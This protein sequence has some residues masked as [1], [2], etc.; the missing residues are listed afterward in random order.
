MQSKNRVY[1]KDLRRFIY[2]QINSEK[3]SNIRYPMPNKI[4]SYPPNVVQ[5][6]NFLNYQYS[7]VPSESYFLNRE[8]N[9]NALGYPRDEG[10]FPVQRNNNLPFSY[11]NNKYKPESKI[12]H[13][14]ISSKKEYTNDGEEDTSSGMPINI[15]K[16]TY[17]IDS[18]NRYKK[19]SI[20]K[21]EENIPPSKIYISET[22]PYNKKEIPH[23]LRPSREKDGYKRGVI[24]LNIKNK[25]GTPDALR[26]IILIQRWWKKNLYNN[27]RNFERYTTVINRQSI[28]RNNPLNNNKEGN[29]FIIQTTRV[30]VFKRPY[31][32]K[33]LIKPE[34]IT[35]ENKVN[36][37]EKNE[38][39]NLEIILDRDSLKQNMVN[40]WNEE[41]VLSP[42]EQLCFI[43]NENFSRE[44][45]LRNAKIKNYE[46]E[47]KQL[48]LALTKKEKELNDLS[49]KLKSFQNKKEL[50]KKLIT[51]QLVDNL[52]INDDKNIIIPYTPSIECTE[53]FEILPIEKEPLKKQL[54]DNLFIQRNLEHIP[55]IVPSIFSEDKTIIEA[56]DNIEIIPLE[57]EPLKKQLIDNLFIEKTI[58]IKPQ[59]I[60]QK[61]DKNSITIANSLN[62]QNSIEANES[63]EIYP[64]QKE[65]L[66]KQFI[67]SLYIKK[68]D[69]IK[70]QNVSE[71]IDNIE[72][73][74]IEE[75]KILEKQL[76]DDL[77][78]EREQSIKP[79]NIAQHIDTLTIYKTQRPDNII[80][81]EYY[82]ELL[83]L[84]TPPL[85]KQFVNDI[86]IEKTLK[87]ENII[88]NIDN[89]YLYEIPKANNLIQARDSIEICSLENEP[90]QLQF[91]DELFIEKIPYSFKNLEMEGFE[92][93]TVLK[94]DKKN[95]YYQE[96][97]AFIIDSL[98]KKENEIQKADLMTILK[99]PRAQN[100][101]EISATI[102]IPSKEKVSLQIEELD[103]VFIE[104]K[105]IIPENQIQN[106]DTLQFN[107]IIKES[108]II[109]EQ[110]NSINLLEKEKD[111]LI[112]Q[113]LDSIILETMPRIEN[114]INPIDTLLIEGISHPLNNI[115]SID[116]VILPAIQKSE[117]EISENIEIYIPP[118]EKEV[119]INQNID[120]IN[121][122]SIQK[123]ENQMQSMDKIYLEEIKKPDFIIQENDYVYIPRKERELNQNQN[124]DSITI[125]SQ[126]KKENI[127]QSLDKIVLNSIDIPDYLIQKSEDLFIE[128]EQ[129][130]PYEFQSVDNLL[131]EGYS[132][133]ENNKIQRID[134]FTIVK[135]F[136]FS[137]RIDKMDT[138]YIP[139]K[140]KTPLTSQIVD[141]IY[142]E[143]NVFQYDNNNQIQK[144]DTINILRKPKEEN[145]IEKNDE[146]ILYPEEKQG[147]L[148]IQSLDQLMIEREPKGELI[149]QGIDK[150]ELQEL[151]KESK[152]YIQI[153]NETFVILSS[154]KIEENKEIS[155]NSIFI[156][157]LD[158]NNYVIE[159]VE[160]IDLLPSKKKS[161][162]DKYNIEALNYIYIPPKEKEKLSTQL[163]ESIFIENEESPEKIFSITEIEAKESIYIPPKEKESLLNENRDSI[164][165]EGFE[166]QENKIEYKD[167]ISIS[168]D[169]KFDTENNKISNEEIIKIQGI[170][171]DQEI[172]NELVNSILIEGVNNNENIKIE[173]IEEINLLEID[174]PKYIIEE[175]EYILITPEEKEELKNIKCD[176]LLIEGESL[177]ENEIQ[178]AECI[179]ILK[180]EKSF[181]YEI[182]LLDSFYLQEITKAPLQYENIDNILF[183]ESVPEKQDQINS[184]VQDINITI[185]PEKKINKLEYQLVDD[186]F[187]EGQDKVQNEIQKLETLI[188]SSTKK[189]F[190][191]M[192]LAD[193]ISLEIKPNLKSPKKPEYKYINQIEK[194]INLYIEPKEK[195]PLENEVMD[196]LTIDG[197]TI[198]EYEVQEILEFTLEKTLKNKDFKPENII[199]LLIKSKDKEPLQ[200]QLADSLFIEKI[201]NEENIIKTDNLN[202]EN[203]CNI[204]I[205]PLTKKDL[206]M[207]NADNF[208]I[209][210]IKLAPLLNEEKEK[211]EDL[212]LPC[213]KNAE[214]EI[215]KAEEIFIGPININEQY[216]IELINKNNLDKD[217]LKL[218][219]KNKEKEEEIKLKPKIEFVKDRMDSL[220]FSGIIKKDNE[221]KEEKE[222]IKDDK[223]VKVKEE[224]K[225]EPEEKDDNV[226]DEEDNEKQKLKAK[227]N[228][229]EKGDKK[230]KEDKE[231]KKDKEESPKIIEHQNN[232]K[233]NPRMFI[234][235]TENREKDFSIKQNI[236]KEE[237][238]KKPKIESQNII[239]HETTLFIQ[240]EKLSQDEKP[241]QKEKLPQK[242][243]YLLYLE[244]WKKEKIPQKAIQL[245]FE[246][247]KE[248]IIV[249]NI[250]EE[251]LIIPKKIPLT[252]VQEE[253]FNLD[254]N[255]PSDPFQE[256]IKTQDNKYYKFKSPIQPKSEINIHIPNTI[257]I[258]PKKEI[259]SLVNL[260]ST[261]LDS[262]NL[263]GNISPEYYQQLILI[264][265]KYLSNKDSIQPTSE[266][267]LFIPKM[268]SSPASN[269][270]QIKQERK[271]EYTPEVKIQVEIKGKQ[272]KPY[273]IENKGYFIINSYTRPSKN[274]IV[275][276]SCFGF[277]AQPKKLGLVSQDFGV[278][279]PP[280]EKNINWNLSNKTQRSQL[281]FI[282]GTNNKITW[283]T[284][285][286]RQKC[287]KFKIPSSKA[288]N[289][290][291]LSINKFFITITGNNLHDQDNLRKQ[292]VVKSII[293]KKPKEKELEENQDEFDPF[294]FCKKR[295]TTKYDNLFKERKT[296]SVKMKE[297]NDNSN[298]IFPPKNLNNKIKGNKD[299]DGIRIITNKERK[300]DINLIE[301]KNKNKLKL[302]NKDNNKPQTLFKKKEKNM[303][304][305]RDSGGPKIFFH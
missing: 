262:F 102:F 35:K 199:H 276:G 273:I 138:L 100:S 73:A 145:K 137:N 278:Q 294:S 82:C 19:I 84:D 224:K 236:K 195:I 295:D 23:K 136:K 249:P 27:K 233:E 58:P 142:I 130:D 256:S 200:K 120:S 4:T 163:A 55:N 259:I 232:I 172:K 135:V 2:P 181:I 119:L 34:I 110:T 48:K 275:R 229:E 187:M 91:I 146:F 121:I 290:D 170:K 40:I 298:I 59:N 114:E 291:I 186:L 43:Q 152:E 24:N 118:K 284:S 197:L 226:K 46:D 202:I 305:I 123:K 159:N 205:Q 303:E 14:S 221:G 52:F 116:T 32:N 304:Y 297:N 257:N 211:K 288:V 223:D 266:I 272:K 161:E 246:S 86:Y 107:E 176:E 33:P 194:K 92:G 65:P 85:Q 244:K 11:I 160:K 7:N 111:L 168:L 10:Q 80:S 37:G 234:N 238:S 250:K 97:D 208:Y 64:L 247:Q 169:K 67:D 129:K 213:K 225:E 79:L 204:Y 267:K 196:R 193:A 164:L 182:E 282:K 300:S 147:I 183:E 88:Q 227:G 180:E 17:C 144:M 167:K 95:I 153:Q 15:D 252:K 289:N 132:D 96:V 71:N 69:K 105:K 98:E 134:Q 63:L 242:E 218:P 281:F 36:F 280:K 149:N 117:N 50:D 263:E 53:N 131:I 122:E 76:V 101:I 8:A 127:I 106:I 203:I 264:Q 151:K 198:P 287:V 292:K 155:V 185:L 113:G 5:K 217:K 285:I 240:N 228:K 103:Y 207:Q 201:K 166:I 209:E 29:Q 89:I 215:H 191:S 66:K 16:K 220:F 251:K 26:N 265:N 175:L 171:K 177:F 57:K 31:M 72:I 75:K 45:I 268:P 139:K 6:K 13:Y 210:G 286:K 189:E 83:P 279:H 255:M 143:E 237:K 21:K 258:P 260:T 78:I 51:R 235:L 150:I 245:K 269:P 18:T 56:R 271:Q 12:Y 99:T 274:L 125:E 41:I 216:I 77:F 126:E 112:N 299:D 206:E 253:S 61:I 212:N 148:L 219:C 81:A 94:V 47:I 254:G 42:N 60:I 44:N 178:K 239:N 296:T 109:I 165:I 68:T 174:R 54:I 28:S 38:E 184:I 231:E 248:N 283:N 179:E 243:I 9:R 20:P 270:E 39:E 104:N 214:N 277:M 22:Y 190:T 156:D 302:F 141:S 62:Y 301:N 3:E 188:I 30:E 173:K 162:A 70:P 157:E 87:P 140:E 154:K 49:N 90:L 108:K 222:K 192:L 133:E 158:K 25:Y 230:E 124:I 261:K 93:I 74:Y 128:P 115:Q 1:D 293:S 241:I